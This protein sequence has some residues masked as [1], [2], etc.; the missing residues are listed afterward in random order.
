MRISDWSS[1][2][3]SSDL[4]DQSNCNKDYSCAKGFCTSF[5]TVLDAE[6]RKPKKAALACEADIILPAPA[7]VPLQDGAYK[8][9][10]PSIGGTGVVTTGQLLGMA[11][12]LEGKDTRLY[13]MPGWS[14]TN[15]AVFCHCPSA[16]FK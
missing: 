9:M 1:D 13:D 2:V 16:A 3:C 5:D 8:I 4:I 12:Q 14:P 15:R 11:A 10:V 7:M 6:P